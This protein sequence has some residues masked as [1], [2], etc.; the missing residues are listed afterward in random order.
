MLEEDM[1]KRGLPLLRKTEEIIEYLKP[2]HYFIENPKT[3]KMKHFM[4]HH[5][6]YDV[7]YCRYADWGYKKS[8]RIWTNK[9]GFKPLCCNKNCGN[10]VDGKHAVQLGGQ[11]GKR[12]S[13]KNRS[14]VPPKLIK[15]LFMC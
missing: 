1:K 4:K 15:E 9:M 8:T 5:T 12:T 6:Y 10:M 2:K 3:G 13:D 11:R 14:R 7:D